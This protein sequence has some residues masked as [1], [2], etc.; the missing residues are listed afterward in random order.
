[1]DQS[2]KQGR[3]EGNLGALDSGLVKTPLSCSN[4]RT[5]VR[6]YGCSVVS[7]HVSLRS[8]GL[9]PP[10]SSLHGFLQARILEWVAVPSSRGSS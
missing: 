6:A 1:M 4:G 8:H 7:S 2:G 3:K 5:G 9:C 10:G